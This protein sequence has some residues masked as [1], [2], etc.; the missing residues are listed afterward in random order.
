MHLYKSFFFAK[1]PYF[2]T[3]LL[4]NNVPSKSLLSV[5]GTKD[6]VSNGGCSNL[7][8]RE[9]DFQKSMYRKKE[10]FDPK[11]MVFSKKKKVFN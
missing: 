6:P 2:F 10:S 9:K 5:R 8:A 4:S 11:M 7:G 3:F 1:C